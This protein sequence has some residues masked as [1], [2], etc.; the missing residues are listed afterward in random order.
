[1]NEHRGVNTDEAIVEFAR[2]LLERTESNAISWARTDHKN[3][4]SYSGTEAS[5]NISQW[6]DEKLEDDVIVLRLLNSR[7]EA[8][9]ELRTSPLL[10]STTGPNNLLQRLHESARRNALRMNDVLESL[11]RDLP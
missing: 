5:V 6:Y 11:R 10:S 9:G 7:G 4:F 2:A 1:M 3:T 8:A